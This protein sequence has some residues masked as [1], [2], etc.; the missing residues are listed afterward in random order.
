[1]RFGVINPA[2]ESVAEAQLNYRYSSKLRDL[3]T[4]P[5]EVAMRLTEARIGEL[6]VRRTNGATVGEFAF[7][8]RSTDGTLMREELTGLCENVRSRCR[9]TPTRRSLLRRWRWNPPPC[10]NPR[11]AP[12][13]TRDDLVRRRR[14]RPHRASA[15]ARRK[16]P[17]GETE[18]RE[19]GPT[20][21]GSRG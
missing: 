14:G 8:I 2:G 4:G 6:A 11:V 20:P 17:V 15:R 10:P 9:R 21:M 3:S 1:M 13:R 19:P 16:V 12:Q 7:E 5:D 18:P